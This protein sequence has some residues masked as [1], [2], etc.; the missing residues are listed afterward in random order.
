MIQQQT[1]LKVSDNSGAKTVKCI[2]VLGGLKKRY[3]YTGDKIIVSV[4]ELR[5][6]SKKT[7]KV[8]KGEI[9]KALIIKSKTKEYQ[10]DG[11]V[12]CFNDNSVTLINKQNQP[13]AS[14]ILT[15]V[16]K[17]L[18]K[19]QFGKFVNISLGTI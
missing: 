9:F 2:K 4:I 7:S 8:K 1:K 13:L 3:A 6:K 18:K 15:P 10:K 11:S 5:N 19:N 17:K 14:R 12:I 16:S